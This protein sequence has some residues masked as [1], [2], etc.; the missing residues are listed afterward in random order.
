MNRKI[1]WESNELD[2]IEL[3]YE[4][5]EN[6]QRIS[7]LLEQLELQTLEEA[8]NNIGMLKTGTGCVL[9]P[10]Q[11]DSFSETD[12]ETVIKVLGNVGIT[13]LDTDMQNAAIIIRLSPLITKVQA[14]TVFNILN[15]IEKL[16]GAITVLIPKWTLNLQVPLGGKKGL[17]QW[18]MLIMLLYPWLSVMEGSTDELAE[19]KR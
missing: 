9:K 16:D 18:E 11:F 14:C 2:E 10:E 4:K 3:V 8:K 6:N 15:R 12:K 1:T 17:L 7:S 13:S 19:V 5:A